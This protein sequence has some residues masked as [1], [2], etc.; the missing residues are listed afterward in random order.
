MN[1]KDEIPVQEVRNI[2]PSSM[3]IYKKYIEE[4]EDSNNYYIINYCDFR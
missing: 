1:E 2:S 3:D 4:I